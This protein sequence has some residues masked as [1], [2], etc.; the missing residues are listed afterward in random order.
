MKVFQRASPNMGVLAV[1]LL[2]TAS[3]SAN[4]KFLN[5]Q[6]K[7]TDNSGSPLTGTQTVTFRL[8]VSSTAG[9]AIWTESQAVALSTGLFNVS[10]GS[11][12]ALD[13]LPFT[14]LYYLGIQ[15][16]G[17]SNELSPR[18]PLGASAYAQGS[19]GD[20]NAGNNFV[21]GGSVA[22]NGSAWIG[23]QAVIGGSVTVK[24]DAFSVGGTSFTVSG[25]SAVVAY[26]LT[27]GQVVAGG[28]VIAAGQVVVVGTMTVQSGAFSV[29]AATFSVSGGSVT[30]GGRLN[31]AAAGIKWADGTLSTT[32]VSVDGRAILAA[33]QTFTGANIFTSTVAIGAAIQTTTATYASI[34]MNG[35]IAISTRPSVGVGAVIFTGL[36]PGYRYRLT[37]SGAQAAGSAS[38]LRLRFNND[39]GSVYG[40]YAADLCTNAGGGSEVGNLNTLTYVPLMEPGGL[41]ASGPF[42]VR[43]EFEDP[44]ANG[45]IRGSCYAQFMASGVIDCVTH[46]CSFIYNNSPLSSVTLYTTNNTF[47]GHFRLEICADR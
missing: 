2:C 33:T 35:C 40:G 32:A 21:A 17:D 34:L 14:Q 44:A 20:F 39:T 9:S 13:S 47:T 25:G 4:S 6:G 29:G 27:A 36:W 31:A 30:L 42:D 16:A 45:V 37:A 1:L 7:L 24:G 46:R 5:V 38:T 3:V 28:Q 15:V 11:V 10:L 41:A 43:A 18:Q 23:A 19:L 8:Y 26:S 22:T 12:T